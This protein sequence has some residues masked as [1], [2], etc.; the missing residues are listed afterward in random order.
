MI[1]RQDT[2]SSVRL[3]VN[4]QLRATIVLKDIQ[5]AGLTRL[6]DPPF[7]LRFLRSARVAVP[8]IALGYGLGMTASG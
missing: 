7:S 4:E 5:L 8:M 3:E 6:V 2:L 1:E